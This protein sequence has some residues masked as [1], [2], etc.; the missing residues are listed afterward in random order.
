MN[1]QLQEA[2]QKFSE[3]VRTATAEGP[4]IVT[5]HGQ[6]IVV[7]LSIAAYRRLAGKSPTLKDYILSSPPFDDLQ[8]GRS[9]TPSR[10]IDS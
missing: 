2:K 5:R 6:E 8:L 9:K 1:W 4:Q 10:P 3:L 7:V